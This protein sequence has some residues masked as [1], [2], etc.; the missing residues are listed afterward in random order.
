MANDLFG[1]LMKGIGAFM[2][3]DDPNVKL[4]QSQS[5][6]SDLQ[7]KIQELYAKIGEKAYPTIK[8]QAEYSDLVAE[9]NFTKKKLKTVE[10]ELQTAQNTKTEQEAKEQEALRS[11]TC[12]NCDTLNPEGV[13]FCQ[14]CG[15]KLNQSTKVKC[16]DCGTEFPIG[17]RFCGE[18]GRQL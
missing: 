6:I 10:D 2:P 14:E 4:F 8:D 16:P 12:P 9:L 18:C 15:A 1:G 11:R 7:N 17:T 3:Q 5:E 13:K